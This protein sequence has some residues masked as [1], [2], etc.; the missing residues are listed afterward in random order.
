[1]TKK[2]MTETKKELNEDVISTLNGLVEICKDGQQGF[3]S[4]AEGVKNSQYKQLFS[5]YA[6]Q[7][8]QFIGELQAEVRRLGGDPEQ[9]GSI[10]GALHRGWINIKSVV[11]GEDEGAIL[12]ECERGEDSAVKA[13]EEALKE[14]LPADVAPVVERQYHLVRQAHDRIRGLERVKDA[15]A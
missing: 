7:R 15:T 14:G 2:E 4:A 8:G 13:Y 9:T 10:A 12:S 5:E 1:M 11:T 6:I 3:Q